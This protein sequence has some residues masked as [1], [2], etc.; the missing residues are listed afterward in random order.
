MYD[1]LPQFSTLQSGMH[2]TSAELLFLKHLG[3]WAKQRIAPRPMLLQGYLT[4]ASSR[5]NWAGIDQEQVIK[6]ANDELAHA[7]QMPQEG[8]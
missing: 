5:A 6:F 3:K 8:Q 7:L 4:A 2:P 1:G